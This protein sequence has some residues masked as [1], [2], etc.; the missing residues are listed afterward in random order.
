MYLDTV[1]TSRS[2]LTFTIFLRQFLRLTLKMNG[3]TALLTAMILSGKFVILSTHHIK[4]RSRIGALAADIHCE[5]PVQ[6]QAG[7]N[8]KRKLKGQ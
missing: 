6:S 2:L 8:M 4:K 1:S 5:I 3:S 7:H